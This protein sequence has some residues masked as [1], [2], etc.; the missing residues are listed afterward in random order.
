MKMVRLMSLLLVAAMLL[1]SVSFAAEE[2]TTVKAAVEAKLAE[3]EAAETEEVETED[4]GSYWWGVTS[5]ALSDADRELIERVVAAEARGCSYEGMIGVAQVIRDRAESWGMTARQIVTAK[6]Q[7]AKP[8]KGEIS[9]DVK[10]AVSAV[11]D[12]GVRVFKEYTT[13]FH[14]TTVNPWWNRSKIKRGAI[15]NH[16]FWGVDPKNA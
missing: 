1:T 3:Q 9:E 12:D 4:M 13:H 2:T 6:S 11:F 16:I 7:F 8:Y 14:N 15:D 5:H 10:N